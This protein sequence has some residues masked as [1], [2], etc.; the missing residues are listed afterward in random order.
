MRLAY[1]L[2]VQ[3]IP[4]SIAIKLLNIYDSNIT[5]FKVFIEGRDVKLIGHRSISFALTSL[6]GGHCELNR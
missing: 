3:G 1:L 2:I 6:S 5:G 4:Q